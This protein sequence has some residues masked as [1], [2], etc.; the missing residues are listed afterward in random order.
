MFSLPFDAF[1]QQP[2]TQ[3]QGA[4]RGI[5]SHFCASHGHF[6]CHASRHVLKRL[7]VNYLEHVHG[8]FITRALDASEKLASPLQKHVHAMQRSFGT[9]DI[10]LNGERSL[11][12]CIVRGRFRNRRQ[13]P[14]LR[15]PPAHLRVGKRRIFQRSA[16]RKQCKKGVDKGP[17]HLLAHRCTMLGRRRQQDRPLAA[18]K[19][20]G[21][22]GI[23]NA[24][25][26]HSG[27]V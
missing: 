9:H 26:A 19:R 20:Y 11:H 24:I 22:Q 16:M 5:N 3:C 4:F 21:G 14:S 17:P 2:L 27:S 7:C 15:A 6:S 8:D 12:A 25:D 18:E 13:S 10:D 23:D 1:S